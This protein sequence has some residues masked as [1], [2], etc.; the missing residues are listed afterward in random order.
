MQE[1]EEQAHSDRVNPRRGD[2]IDGRRQTLGIQGSDDPARAHPFPDHESQVARHQRRRP[3]PGEVVERGAVLPADL[4]QIPETLGGDQRSAAAPSLQQRVRG[5]RRAVR[6]NPYPVGILGQRQP[7]IEHG[8]RRVPRR[9]RH[10]RGADAAGA[11]DRDHVGE[12]AA[13]VDTQPQLWPRRAIA[14]RFG[15]PSGLVAHRNDS[16]RIYHSCWSLHWTRRPN[17][18]TVD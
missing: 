4:D 10:F 11:V 9:G 5:H 12:R 1:P 15:I 7:P 16:R 2:R 8:R 3:V 6:E 14:R 17:P 18:A 13:H